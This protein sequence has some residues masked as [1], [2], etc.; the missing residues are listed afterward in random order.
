MLKTTQ[1]VPVLKW[2]QGEYQA[3]FRLDAAVKDR[4]VPLIE[5]TPPEWDFELA[6][7][8][9]SIDEHLVKFAPRLKQKWGE[10]LAYLYAGHIP[11]GQTMADGSHP[12]TYL[13]DSARAEGGRLIPVTTLTRPA[14]FQNAV[15]NAIAVD[16][17]GFALRCGLEELTDPDFS[18][19]LA[20]LCAILG[21][22][23][24]NVDVILDLGAPA[25]QSGFAHMISAVINY[26]PALSAVRNLVVVATAFPEQFKAVPTLLVTFPRREWDLYKEIIGLAPARIPVFGDYAIAVPELVSG[27]MRLLKPSA[28]VRYATNGAWIIAKGTN[29]R[30]NGFGQFQNCCAAIR[31]DAAYLGPSYSPGS[32][33]IADCSVGTVSTGNLTTWRWV[34]TNHHITKIVDD[35]ANFH[36]P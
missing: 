21:T 22:S 12:V 24:S 31:K 6:K 28:T 32:Q 29:V 35:L 14:T 7:Q 17:R 11:D 2:R 1:Y 3:L 23:L 9:K 36:V 8:A 20:T 15:K 25:F 16:G 18:N 34:G 30:D 5:V 10:R 13:L 27:D 4:I 26:T 19:N 33:Y